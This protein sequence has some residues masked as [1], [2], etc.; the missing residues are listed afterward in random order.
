MSYKDRV[1]VVEAL[2]RNRAMSFDP[3]GAAGCIHLGS[4]SVG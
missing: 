3:N 2:L 4:C 1:D